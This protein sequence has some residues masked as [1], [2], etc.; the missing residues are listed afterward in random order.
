MD[1]SEYIKKK[2]KELKNKFYLKY[3]I[4]HEYFQFYLKM[5][6]ETDYILNNDKHL[7][8]EDINILNDKIN[9]QFEEVLYKYLRLQTNMSDCKDFYSESQVYRFLSKKKEEIKKDPIYYENLKLFVNSCKIKPYTITKI[10]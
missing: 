9:L 5:K 4:F 1:Y 10:I 6:K 8:E 3:A 7:S 2:K